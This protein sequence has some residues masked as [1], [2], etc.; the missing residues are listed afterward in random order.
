MIE[1]M[2]CRKAAEINSE[3]AKKLGPSLILNGRKA[4][5]S[6]SVASMIAAEMKF[7]AC[8]YK[9]SGNVLIAPA[10]EAHWTA[11]QRVMGEVHMRDERPRDIWDQ[12]EAILEAICAADA[13]GA[14]SLAGQHIMQAANFM[15]HRL[16]SQEGGRDST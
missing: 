3:R 5:K 4:V 14:E 1:G 13:L 10:M 16:R 7:H 8:I 15:I 11:T 12:H 2:A 6:G 9:L